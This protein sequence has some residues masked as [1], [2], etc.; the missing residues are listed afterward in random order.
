MSEKFT[1]Q[2][3]EEDYRIVSADGDEGQMVP[4][5]S[6]AT[7]WLEGDS[8]P[9]VYFCLVTDPDDE[10]PQVYCTDS[11]HRCQTEAEEVEFPP[12]IVAA[13]RRLDEAL[14]ADEADDTTIEVSPAPQN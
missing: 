13:Q 2:M 6:L 12:A 5:G 9:M 14:E 8:V 11:V 3:G 7:L 10:K 1:V 4:Y